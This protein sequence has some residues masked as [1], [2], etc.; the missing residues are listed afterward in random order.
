MGGGRLLSAAYG[1]ADLADLR[2]EDAREG[3]HLRAP[4]REREA[5]GYEPVAL[6][7]VT[8]ARLCWGM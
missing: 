8:K 2:G 7:G 1:L 4:E 5:T 6:H 3:L